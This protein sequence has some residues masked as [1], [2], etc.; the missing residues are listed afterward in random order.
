MLGNGSEVKQGH[1]LACVGKPLSKK[2]NNID[3]LYV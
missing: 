1:K 3:K 2:F